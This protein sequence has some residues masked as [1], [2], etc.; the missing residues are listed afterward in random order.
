[1]GAACKPLLVKIIL[2]RIVYFGHIVD[3][4]KKRV[5]Y[6]E[7]SFLLD[8]IFHGVSPLIL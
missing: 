8:R 6:I 4:S 2:V 3:A 5:A 7:P 1:M